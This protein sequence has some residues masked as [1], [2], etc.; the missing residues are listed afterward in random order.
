MNA[1]FAGL[2]LLACASLVPAHAMMQVR[3][4]NYT[5]VVHNPDGT[6]ETYP[7]TYCWWEW[8]PEP[9]DPPYIPP[10]IPA[11]PG[12]PVVPNPN[13]CQNT[14]DNWPAGCSKMGRP[15]VDVNGCTHAPDS[16][17][18]ANITPACN[19]H[20]RCY[21]TY[22][23]TKASCDNALYADIVDRCHMAYDNLI[24]S[25]N[26]PNGYADEIMLDDYRAQLWACEAGAN[27]F[28][29]AVWAVP[30]STYYDPA[31]KV[32]KCIKAHDDRD[33]YCGD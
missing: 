24:A 26:P 31:Q 29:A 14:L 28:A 5:T 4:S 21:S 16:L 15:V 32:G 7:G 33:K 30:A 2:L 22:G 11:P 10:I 1:L 18:R 20:D 8:S 9:Y 13:M 17:G 23:S 25:V 19:Q 3:C 6:T 27:A 12:Y